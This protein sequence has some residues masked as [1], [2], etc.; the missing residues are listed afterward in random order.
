MMIGALDSDAILAFSVISIVISMVSAGIA[1]WYQREVPAVLWILGAF[2]VAISFISFGMPKSLPA[3]V[4]LTYIAY[5]AVIGAI[6]GVV[7]HFL[8]HGALGVADIIAFIFAMPFLVMSWASF[9]V[10]VAVTGVLVYRNAGAALR[11]DVAIDPNSST[12]KKFIPT[13]IVLPDGRT[14]VLPKNLKS[15]WQAAKAAPPGSKIYG[16][17][18]VPIVTILMGGV[19][20]TFIVLMAVAISVA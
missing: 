1:G 20:A 6:I 10:G 8:T 14:M 18:A 19:I 17:Y 3:V 16:K 15:A 2:G 9:L 7:H 11:H 12:A 13:K 4:A 5:G